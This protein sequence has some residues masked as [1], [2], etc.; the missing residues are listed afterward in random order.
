MEN[1]FIIKYRRLDER[2][3]KAVNETL[4]REY[5]Y[6]HISSSDNDDT[7]K[8]SNNLNTTKKTEK[9]NE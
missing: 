7:S 3:K 5:S 9:L 1:D 6:V 2:G 8:I 4:E